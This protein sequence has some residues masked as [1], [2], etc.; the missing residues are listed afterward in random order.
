M[1]QFCTRNM[2]GGPRR[3]ALERWIVFLRNG[4][5][6]PIDYE[7]C[8][9]SMGTKLQLRPQSPHVAPVSARN[10]LVE[11][12]A[13]LDRR[14]ARGPISGQI[15]KALP[16]TVDVNASLARVRTFLAFAYPICVP[17]RSD[18]CVPS[19]Y[20]SCVPLGVRKRVRKKIR[21]TLISNAYRIRGGD[22]WTRTNDP[23]DVNDVL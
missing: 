17:V 12:M 15:R 22:S 4:P 1:I 8:L 13:L 7:L 18:F 19:A 21:Q 3:R 5:Y 14:A 10:W 11:E 20:P 16:G 23:I 2:C 9:K 6:R